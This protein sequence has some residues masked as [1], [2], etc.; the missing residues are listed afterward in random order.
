MRSVAGPAVGRE[1][2]DADRGGDR[3]RPAL[4]ADERPVAERLEDPLGGVPGLVAVGLGQDDREL[5]AAVA[6]R[7]VRRAQRRPDE[8]RG[9]GQDPV[10]EQVA[11]R[12]VDELEVVE[13]EHQHAQRAPAALGA[14][15]LLAQPLVQEAVVVEAGQR[16]AVGELAGVLVEAGVL[17]RHRR[18]VGH[19]PGELEP[20]VRPSGPPICENSSTRPI[21][22]PLA[23]SGSIASIRLPSST[24]QRDLGRVGGR[25]LGVDDHRLPAL[26]DAQRLRVAGDARSTARAPRAAAAGSSRAIRAGPIGRSQ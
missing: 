20:L 15:D 16:V 2:G 23:T 26:E 21:A 25:V 8:L 10:A 17:E 18:L 3:H 22:W 19:R 12:V 7:D 5:V 13:V 9:P 14:D 1:R 4:L 24:Q 11:E 6:G